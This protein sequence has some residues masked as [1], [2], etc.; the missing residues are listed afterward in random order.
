MSSSVD[1]MEKE[2]KEFRRD[3]AKCQEALKYETQNHHDTQL[4]LVCPNTI[5]LFLLKMLNVLLQK[6]AEKLATLSKKDSEDFQ[7][8][9]EEE[10]K[11]SSQ[12]IS[13][14]RERVRELEEDLAKNS[15]R[16]IGEKATEN[17][18]QTS[19]LLVAE[20][21]RTERSTSPLPAPG[22]IECGSSPLRIGPVSCDRVTQTEEAL[23]P[24]ESECQTDE[25]EDETTKELRKTKESL[26]IALSDLQLKNSELQHETVIHAM[27]R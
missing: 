5:F 9:M 27:E 23:A 24:V 12:T 14:L 10:K 19:L 16:A 22:V 11:K 4:A 7:W 17:E 13:Q 1:E 26:E 21:E 15:E 18:C 20:A 25:L 8:L 2:L 6:R 3:L